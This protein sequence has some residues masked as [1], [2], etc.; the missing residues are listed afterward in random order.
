M[1]IVRVASAGLVCEV[2]AERIRGAAERAAQEEAELIA[3][4]FS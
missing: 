4:Q 1:A 2:L 3:M